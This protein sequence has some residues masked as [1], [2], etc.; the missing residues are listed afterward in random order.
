MLQLQ[1]NQFK[2]KEG[3]VCVCQLRPEEGGT[4]HTMQLSGGR[5]SQGE[6]EKEQRP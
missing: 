3:N 1:N 5:I 2:K 6:Q 4:E